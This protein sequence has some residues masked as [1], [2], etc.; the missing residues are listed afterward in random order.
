MNTRG[1]ALDAADP[2]AGF[3]ERFAFPDPNLVYL[4]GNS[5]GRMPL[6][7]RDRAVRLADHEWGDRLIRSWNEGWWEAPLR[8]GD[9]LAPLVGAQSGEVAIADATSVNLYKLTVAA[10]LAQQGRTRIVTDDM[11]FPSDLYVLDGVATTLDRGHV[12]EIVPSADGIHGPA[13]ELSATL[14]PSVALVTLSH[15]TY[16][17]GYRYDIAAVTEAAH[18]VGA[19]VLWDLSHSVGA[20]PIDISAADLAIGCTYKYLNGGPGAPAFIYVHRDLQDRL[21]NPISGWWGHHAPFDFDPSYAAA[22]GMRRFL[23]GTAPMASLATIE[24][25]LDLMHEAGIDR[26]AAKSAAQSAYFLDRWQDELA[27]LGFTLNSPPDAAYRGSHVSLGHAAGLGI[28][29]ALINDYD[30]LPD[31]RPPDNLRFGIAPLYTRFADIDS[32]VDAMVEIVTEER[33]AS[34]LDRRPTVT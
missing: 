28:D 25:G 20:V 7:A 27:P 31:F 15:V 30:V 16:K 2:L 4:D 8:L 24:P 26:L 3:R 18:R 32:A 11:N 21:T 23:T 22:T 6:A 29:L 9:K 14:D 5:L 12:V 34:Y 1:A 13:A 33:F 17:S 19:L 10:L